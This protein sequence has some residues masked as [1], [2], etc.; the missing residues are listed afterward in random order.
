[1]SNK[2]L[3][4]RAAAARCLAAVANGASLTQQIP[5]FEHSVT[6]RDQSLF[7]QLCYGT[8]RLY[9]RLSGI[10]KQ[11]VK[12]P[13]KEKDQDV[14]M[15]I[16]LGGYQLTETRVPEHAAIS[17]TVAAIRDLKKP[18]AKGFVNGVLRQW[19]RQHPSLLEQLTPAE[20]VAHPEWFYQAINDAWPDQAGVIFHSNNEHPP[21]CLRVNSQRSNVIEYLQHLKSSDIEAISCEF[22]EQGI[23]LQHPLAVE[24]LP[25]FQQGWCSIQDEAPQ[26]SASL[27]SLKPGLRVLDACCAPGGKTCHII[28]TEPQL[29]EVV[30]LDVDE[31][32]LQRVEEN[33]HRL[34]LK[35]T[36][37]SGDA[38]K[39]DNWW[40]GKLF[41]RILLDAPCSA[42]GVIRRNPD[43]KLH[44]R[45][46]DIDKLA[47]LQAEILQ[48]LWPTLKPG[49]LL[50]YATCSVLPAENEHIIAAFCQRQGDA[51][52]VVIDTNWGLVRDHGRQLFP[53]PQ[54]HDGFYYALLE[55]KL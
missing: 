23:R 53:Q 39:P 11:L 51:K 4:C 1:M 38:G 5:L 55:K 35:A 49:G 22:A 2:R 17:A 45:A 18:W 37:L 46:A 54:G 42:S 40:D 43:I 31:L 12:K 36:L 7:R 14:W 52:H 34:Q 9:P 19:Q 6:P 24:K 29:T 28:E 32:R 44:R 27:L 41:D 25:H 3:E 50:L 20:V 16:L 21:M 13:L 47:L 48:A 30:A 10:V 15:L 26:L 8:L 33:L